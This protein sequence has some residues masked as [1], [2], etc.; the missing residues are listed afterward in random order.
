MN[1]ETKKGNYS[2]SGVMRRCHNNRDKKN[3]SNQS[4]QTQPHHATKT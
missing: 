1:S 3:K 4:P 2:S